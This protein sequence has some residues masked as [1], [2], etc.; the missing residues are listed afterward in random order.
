MESRGRKKV[1][2]LDSG[3]PSCRSWWSRRGTAV[4]H[5]GDR[6]SPPLPPDCQQRMRIFTLL[7]LLG[8]VLLYFREKFPRFL[9]AATWCL[10]A[11]GVRS[12]SMDSTMARGQCTPRGN[13][14]GA[15]ASPGCGSAFIPVGL[16]NSCHLHGTRC[17][18]LQWHIS[19]NKY[20]T[21]RH[22]PLLGNAWCSWV[23]RLLEAVP[24]LHCSGG[25]KAPESSL[26]WSVAS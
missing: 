18:G 15:G 6:A 17:K 7:A 5:P 10:C 3:L 14:R 12:Q 1:E 4:G 9:E 13:G 8:S 24:V 22:S 16:K 21:L 20:F 19:G 23:F 26:N 25:E 2:R 11:A